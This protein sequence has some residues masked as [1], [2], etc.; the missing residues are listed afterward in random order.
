M[1]VIKISSDIMWTN[2]RYVPN[3]AYLEWLTNPTKAKKML[4]SRTNERW[5]KIKE[6]TEMK[7][8]KFALN[9]KFWEKEMNYIKKS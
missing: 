1:I 4:A 3:V 9:M 7:I 6:S 2:D 8:T 5:N